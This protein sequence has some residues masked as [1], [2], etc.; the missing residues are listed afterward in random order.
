[1]VHGSRD[2]EISGCMRKTIMMMGKIDEKG[3]SYIQGRNWQSGVAAGYITWGIMTSTVQTNDIS[4]ILHLSLNVVK[5]RYHVDK[6]ALFGS[7]ARGDAREDSD[8]DILV[9]FVPG[10]DLLDLS[11]LKLYFE[12]IFGRPVDV[13]PRR[14]IREELREAILADAVDI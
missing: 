3:I 1:M 12:D 2:L 7:H 11:G 8:I 5:D 13:V 14:A 4:S 10:A 6:L 9:D